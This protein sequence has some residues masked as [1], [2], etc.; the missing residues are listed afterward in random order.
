MAEVPWAIISKDLNTTVDPK[1]SVVGQFFLEKG[2][3]V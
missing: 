3:N 1:T 2:E